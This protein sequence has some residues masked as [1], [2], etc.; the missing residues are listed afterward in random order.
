MAIPSRNASRPGT[1]FIT[2]PTYN[3][4]RVFQVTA[5]CDLFLKTLEHYRPSYRL[6]AYVLMPDH[7]HLLL[8]PIEGIT[9]ERCMQ[10]IKGGFSH[11]MSSKTPVWQRG[12]SDHRIR[13]E[14]EFLAHLRYI[15]ENPVAARFVDKP[16]DYPHSSINV[17]IRL[18]SY[19]SG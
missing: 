19:L 14:S 8:T 1:Y 3:R 6:H 18:D 4:R 11:R 2:A 17:A 15:H 10:L 16:E 7:V 5:N 12:F 9:I 13:D